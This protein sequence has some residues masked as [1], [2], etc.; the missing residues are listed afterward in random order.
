MSRELL[1]GVARANIT[2]PVGID[3]VG[4]GL[5]M[6]IHDDLL[7]KALVLS[8]GATSLAVISADLLNFDMNIVNDVR[9]MI[10]ERAGIPRRN[11]LIAASHNHASPVTHVHDRRGKRDETYVKVL[12]KKLAGAVYEA[13]RNLRQANLGIGKGHV[14]LLYTSDAAD[15]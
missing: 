15:E 9:G 2:P 8:D 14:C 13:S 6:G 12:E 7:A 10:E 1:A 5:S 11:V 3:M 4:G